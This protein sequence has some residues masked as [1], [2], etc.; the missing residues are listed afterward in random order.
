MIV[1]LVL[2]LTLF[3]CGVMERPQI[4]RTPANQEV[5]SRLLP[6]LEDF[7][8]E[9][10]RFRK[11]CDT[12]IAAVQSLK[13]VKDF[14]HEPSLSPETVGVCLLS[15]PSA[16]IEIREDQLGTSKRY[17][18]AIVYHELTHCAYYIDHVS[19]KGTLISEYIP[20]FIVLNTKWDRLITELFQEIGARYAD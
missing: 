5:D 7:R 19:R 11:D 4:V 8:K 1:K 2:L 13:V 6:Y 10:K 20:D 3:A 16:R 14:A 17:M 9:C 12:R 15:F 18:R